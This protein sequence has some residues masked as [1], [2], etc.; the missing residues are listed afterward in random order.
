METIKDISPN[1]TQIPNDYLDVFMP[2]LT[3]AEWKCL[4]Y[5]ARRTFGFQKRAD[6]IAFSQF[7][8]GITTKD[9]KVLDYGTGL[10]RPKIS[11][12]LQ[13]LIEVGLLESKDKGNS[14]EYLL[15]KK[16]NQLEVVKKL[17]QT[18]KESLP[19]VVKKLN[20]QKKE[21]E[22]IQKKDIFSGKPLNNVSEII[23][24]FELVDPKNKTYYAN[25]GQRMACQFMID[26][27]GFDRVCKVIELLPNTNQLDYFPRITSPYEL[28][29][30]WTKLA[31]ALQSKKRNE[32]FSQIII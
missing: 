10:S 19:K 21:K 7:E 17:N 27:Y 28:K 5:I 14:K 30:K 9:G 13:K 32:D 22:S 6:Q 25:K 20:I 23:K 12:S 31:T 18:G 29:E 2:H 15:V 24:Q 3:G 16:L 26:E 8:N 1:H 4:C 11:E